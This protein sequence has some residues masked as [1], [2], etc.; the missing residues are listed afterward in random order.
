[1]VA[2]KSQIIQQQLDRTKRG[3]TMYNYRKGALIVAVFIVG[4]NKLKCNSI[5]TIIG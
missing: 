3:L 5:A 1:M 4:K 2:A